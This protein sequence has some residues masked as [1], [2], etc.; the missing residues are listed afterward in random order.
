MLLKIPICLITGTPTG[1][2]EIWII[3]DT[4]MVS[5]ARS[6]LIDLADIEAFNRKEPKSKLPYMLQN[7]EVL[8][9]SFHHSWCFTTQILGGLN[10]L[11]ADKWKLPNYIYIL[12]S[13]DQIHDS[14]ELGEEL[15]P[16]L[17]ELFTAINRALIS[18]REILPKKAKRYKPPTVCVVRTV[19][20]SNRKQEEKNFKN[21]RR[22]LN[23]ALQRTALKFKWRTINIDTILPKQDKHFDDN[24]DEL[25]KEGFRVFWSFLSEDLQAFERPITSSNKTFKNCSYAKRQDYYNTYY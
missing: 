6:V 17:E 19:P 5:Q 11:L 13:N 22:T 24:G 2:D 14:E 3:G 1:Y 21:K 25:S 23:R 9:G 8:S 7:Y 16:V 4:H 12:F 10:S 15:Y 20:K 18:R